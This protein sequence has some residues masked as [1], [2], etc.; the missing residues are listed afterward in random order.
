MDDASESEWDYVYKHTNAYRKAILQKITEEHAP[1]FIFADGKYAQKAVTEIFGSADNVVLIPRD[2][3]ANSSGL[4]ETLQK[5]KAEYEGFEEVSTQV[6]MQSIPRSHLPFYARVWE[7]TAGDRVM[8]TN[9]FERG[10]SFMFIAPK[11]IRESNP[12]NWHMTHTKKMLKKLEELGFPRPSEN[13]P[14]YLKRVGTQEDQMKK[15]G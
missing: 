4:K 14:D 8:N 6:S 15:A 3:L 1:A 11:E 12:V 10:K 9:A 2:G 13:L 5:L 7:G